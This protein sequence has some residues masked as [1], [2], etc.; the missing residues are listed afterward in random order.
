MKKFIKRI[1]SLA[2]VTSFVLPSVQVFAVNPDT[3]KTA[4]INETELK[5]ENTELSTFEDSE[6]P[7]VI[8]PT[9]QRD[10]KTSEMA[11]SRKLEDSDVE[12]ISPTMQRDLKTSEMANLAFEDSNVE[13][14]SPTMQRDLKTSE[15]AN[16]LPDDAPKV[17]SPTMQQDLQTSEVPDSR[18]A[19]SSRGAFSTFS[20]ENVSAS[21]SDSASIVIS[22]IASTSIKVKVTYP[23]ST[24]WGNRLEIHEVDTEIWRVI[25]DPYN[26]ADGVYSITNL[27]L[28]T[29]YRVRLTWHEN[30]EWHYKDA[31]ITTNSA[32]IL[33]SE[34]TNDSINVN[35]TYP[36]STAWGNR[37]EIHDMD[38]NTWRDIT[39][40]YNTVDGIYSIMNL[41]SNTNYR[42]RQTWYNDG[43]HYEDA[44][45]KTNL[46]SIS[47]LEVTNNSV[48]VKV[49]YPDS[50][51]WGNRLEIQD[52][53]ADAWQ[54]ITNTYSTTN[55][56]YSISNLKLN[57]LYRVRITWYDEGWNF[58][59]IFVTTNLASVVVSEVTSDSLKV[60]V[61]YPDSAAWGNRLEIEDVKNGV[62]HDITNTY[63]TASG[64]YSIPNLTPNTYYRVRL[65]WN[66]N[67]WLYKDTFVTTGTGSG[68][69][70]QIQD[71]E[72]LVDNAENNLLSTTDATINVTGKIL[73]KN[74]ISSAKY[75]YFSVAD[76]TKVTGSLD[77][78][79]NWTIN[80]MP[81]NIGT[82]YLILEAED[83]GGQLKEYNLIISRISTEVEFAENVTSLTGSISNKVVSSIHEFWMLD[84]S[85]M[86]LLVDKN[87]DLIT[88]YKKDD[89]LILEP[90]EALPAG[91]SLKIDGAGEVGELLVYRDAEYHEYINQLDAENKYKLIYTKN[92][93]IDEILT[94][95]C[96]IEFN[97]IDQ[98]NP[99]AFV[100]MPTNTTISSVNDDGSMAT[101]AR[102]DTF[103][104]ISL[105]AN[106]EDSNDDT[107]EEPSIVEKWENLFNAIS[108]RAIYSDKNF[109]DKKYPDG[110]ARGNISFKIEN[111]LLPIEAEHLKTKA[112]NKTGIKGRPNLTISS[113]FEIT[114]IDIVSD[115]EMH[116][117]FLSSFT[118]DISFKIKTEASVELESKIDYSEKDTTFFPFPT[119]NKEGAPIK[120]GDAIPGIGIKGV[121]LKNELHLATVGFNLLAPGTVVDS[122]TAPLMPAVIIFSIYFDGSGKISGKVSFGFSNNVNIEQSKKTISDK[123]NLETEIKILEQ[124][125]KSTVTTKNVG[126][127]YTLLESKAQKDSLNGDFA[128][129]GK[130]FIKSAA[131]FETTNELGLMTGA[132]F[133][134]ITP[135]RGYIKGGLKTKTS[136]LGEF[137]Y[138]WQDGLFDRNHETYKNVH[139][140][141]VTEP[142]LTAGYDFR[143]S[144]VLEKTDGKEHDLITLAANDA[145]NLLDVLGI[146]TVKL[147]KVIGGFNGIEGVMKN[148]DGEIL[149]DVKIEATFKSGDTTTVHTGSDGRFAFDFDVSIVDDKN[150]AG[151]LVLKFSKDG[152]ITRE[153]TI[154]K[155]NKSYEFMNVVLEDNVENSGTVVLRVYNPDVRKNAKVTLLYGLNYRPVQE[156][157]GGQSFNSGS[158]YIK[159][160]N[161]KD[162]DYTLVVTAPG[163]AP[164]II[165]ITINNQANVEKT[166]FL[167]DSSDGKTG[168]LIGNV[169]ANNPQYLFAYKGI[170][171]YFISGTSNL[172]RLS[173]HDKF[174]ILVEPTTKSDLYNFNIYENSK[175]SIVSSIWINEVVKDYAEIEI[176]DSEVKTLQIFAR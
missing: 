70:E 58:D 33:V 52:V 49:T 129:R 74:Q 63:N 121:D 141:I 34:V 50:A 75:T 10:L 29:L 90:S 144:A 128:E 165:D 77:N 166:I 22:E 40:T 174:Y 55:G 113:K 15:M 37:L 115:L 171:P 97:E 24:A 73:S 162:N 64:V 12:I 167:D 36:D 111:G 84:D 92:P 8:S 155:E 21:L 176:A 41:K 170:N 76:D 169:Y 67:G 82:N 103:G 99:I 72:I 156:L 5:R 132:M 147:Q 140:E 11:N 116:N 157:K 110:K 107:P 80:N 100:Y 79:S 96:K 62:W 117:G 106:D 112:G 93:R 32:T 9:M 173:S 31:F 108:F 150:L 18:N 26:T 95:D 61:T 54:D 20:L 137:S 139:A 91:L 69:D 118:E 127:G 2:L 53:K 148:D 59:D 153:I 94:G 57:T 43:W 83:V 124:K 35:V 126:F 163:K 17:I 143:L 172:V 114:D 149:E 102:S 161:L 45:V 39:N 98:E 87:S 142:I 13:V 28:N 4:E 158:D 86:A 65:T 19:R 104:N 109:A 68:T 101:I 151:N 85:S 130:T 123:H 7:E 146:E 136:M 78:F 159:Y 14:I 164:Q 16:S 119:F 152:Y 30:N 38:S 105:F 44:F 3:V 56:V 66:T 135:I 125:T 6:L 46:A 27:K 160:S 133:F 51:A 138:L 71:I 48:E 25:T 154:T 168:V 175:I 131:S 60:N 42:I 145:I 134:G 47:V 89:I 88:K 122:E 1:I 23:D 81:L 120:T